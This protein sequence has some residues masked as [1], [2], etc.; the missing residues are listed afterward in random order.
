[1]SERDGSFLQV[2]QMVADAVRDVGSIPSGHLYA[3][4]MNTLRLDQYNQIIGIL[5]GAGLV[6]E[7]RAHMLRWVGPKFDANGQRVST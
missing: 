6:A 1:M 3:Q 7:D 4:V 2:V 5:K